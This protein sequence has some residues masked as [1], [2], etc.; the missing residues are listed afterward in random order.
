MMRLP[1]RQQHADNRLN[2]MNQPCQSVRV[3]RVPQLLQIAIRQLAA[4]HLNT[5]RRRIGLEKLPSDPSVRPL[6]LLQKLCLFIRLRNGLS[7][8]THHPTTEAAKR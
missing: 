8:H 4:G 1:E 5:Q 7:S 3:I 6:R 2:T